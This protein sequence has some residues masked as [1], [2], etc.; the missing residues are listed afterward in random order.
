MGALR[1]KKSNLKFILKKS[2]AISLNRVLNLNSF[3]RSVTLL[4]NKIAWAY[5]SFLKV[6]NVYWLCGKILLKLPSGIK[7]RVKLSAV[8]FLKTSTIPNTKLKASSYGVHFKRPHV[9]GVAKNAVDHP[10][11]GKGRSG[12]KKKKS[13]WGWHL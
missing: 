13:P 3:H 6:V 10:N 8:T 12:L 2:T 11:G 4:S 7:R 5:N 9:R 1:I